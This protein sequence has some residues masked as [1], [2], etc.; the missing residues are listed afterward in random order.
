MS[1]GELVTLGIFDN[2][3]FQSE[4]LFLLVIIMLFGAIGIAGRSFTLGVFGAYLTFIHIVTA[5]GSNVPELNVAMWAIMGV[6][7]LF[8]AFRLWGHV[9]GGGSAPG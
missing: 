3:V 7:V 4:L 5:V 6:L 1:G 9:S 8:V 2:P